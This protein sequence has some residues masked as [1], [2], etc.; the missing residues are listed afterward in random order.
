MRRSKRAKI[1]AA[2]DIADALADAANALADLADDL[3]MIAHEDDTEFCLASSDTFIPVDEETFQLWDP[4]T[5]A[6]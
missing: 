1:Q 2:R 6:N 4:N 3:E 5:Q